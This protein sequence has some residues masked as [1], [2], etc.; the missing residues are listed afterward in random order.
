MS[1]LFAP[2]CKCRFVRKMD[3]HSSTYAFPTGR[4]VIKVSNLTSHHSWYLNHNQLWWLW[5][6]WFWY[7]IK[8]QWLNAEK[9]DLTTSAFE[10][11]IVHQIVDSMTTIRSWQSQTYHCKLLSNAVRHISNPSQFTQTPPLSHTCTKFRIAH[12]HT[13]TYPESESCLFTLTRI[14]LKDQ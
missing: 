14:E 8:I 6:I 11:N 10:S 9:W 1:V 4:S 5:R 13:G 12:L 3:P 7:S 2:S